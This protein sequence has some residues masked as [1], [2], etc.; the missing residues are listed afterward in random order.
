MSPIPLQVHGLDRED[1]C[2]DHWGAIEAIR[3]SKEAVRPTPAPGS[4]DPPS[5][6]LLAIW[7][8][9]AGL[10]TRTV[11]PKYNALLRLKAD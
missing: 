1:T 5:Y 7:P 10:C 8:N 6:Q 11:Q 3:E 4:K 9:S 2:R